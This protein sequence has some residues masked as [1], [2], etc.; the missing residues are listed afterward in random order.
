MVVRAQPPPNLPDAAVAVAPQRPAPADDEIG[1]WIAE[2]SHDQYSVRQAAMERLLTAGFAARPALLDVADGPDPEVRASARRLVAL[3][4]QSEFSRRLAEFAA[5]VDGRRGVTLPGW[6]EFGELVGRDEAARNLFVEM[7]REEAPLLTQAFDRPDGFRGIEWENRLMRLLT[8]PLLGRRR[9]APAPLGSC[10]TLFFL[11]SL[12]NA[13]ISDNTAMY[14]VQLAQRPPMSDALQPQRGDGAV[15]RVLSAWLV[16]CASRR[17]DVLI[18][19]LSLILAYELVDALP[20]ALDIAG[21]DPQL[22]TNSA[23]QR[24]TALQ[25][26]GRFGS[27]EHAA[28]L[29]PLLDDSTQIVPP[30]NAA[31]RPAYSVE[32]RDVALATM[33]HLT[34]QNLKDYGFMRARRYPATVFDP[35]SLGMESDE[36]RAAAITQWREWRAAHP[37][38]ADGTR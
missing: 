38:T 1:R 15:R 5:D 11:A 9:D 22:A 3:I 10:A 31:Q 4:D 25:V 13:T 21:T 33:L 28:T 36:R 26:V 29:E 20:L 18:G 12:D 16:R 17:D 2:L 7:Q 8:L 6:K 19:R 27:A 35:R 34:G 23:A 24:V 37:L 14:L 30:P 32:V